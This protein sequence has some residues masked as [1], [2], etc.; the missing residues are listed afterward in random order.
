MVRWQYNETINDLLGTGE[1]DKRKHEIKH[2]KSG[3]TTVT[4]VVTSA[5]YFSP[6]L[7]TLVKQYTGP[8][9]GPSQVA[10]LLQHAQS[11]RAVATTWMN[12]RSSRSH[13][14]F[15]L[16]VSGMN[17]ITREACEGS[18][19]LVVRSFPFPFSP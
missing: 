1:L 14:V 6:L 10:S 3:R 19:N 18:L 4:E 8:L 15:T 2:D 11:R 16:R 17:R 7:Y 12:E 5:F 13:S 9:T